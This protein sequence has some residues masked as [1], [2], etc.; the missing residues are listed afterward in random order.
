MSATGMSAG[1]DPP[2]VATAPTQSVMGGPPPEAPAASGA[3]GEGAPA[4][5]PARPSEEELQYLRRALAAAQQREEEALVQAA[6]AR[7]NLEVQLAEARAAAQHFASQAAPEPGPTVQVQMGPPSVAPAYQT[8]RQSVAA[9][10]FPQLVAPVAPPVAQLAPAGSGRATVYGPTV[11]ARHDSAVAHALGYDA[12][13][14]IRHTAEAAARQKELERLATVR[15]MV[16]TAPPAVGTYGY[17][18]PTQDSFY[19]E[20]NFT[21]DPTFQGPGMLPKELSSVQME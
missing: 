1:P 10:V 2:D 4:A 13:D 19:S 14:L 3:T 15:P 8:Y 18:V 16:P 5:P 7:L 12:G 21:L 20:D 6:S 9:P 11:R 17:A